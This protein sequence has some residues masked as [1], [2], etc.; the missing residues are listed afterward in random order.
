MDAFNNWRI[1]MMAECQG[2]YVVRLSVYSLLS[3]KKRFHA[4]WRARVKTIVRRLQNR[5]MTET[6]VLS[7]ILLK[8][9]LSICLRNLIR[10]TST[11]A[12]GSI[13]SRYTRPLPPTVLAKI[14]G[15]NKGK[16]FGKDATAG[17]D[18]QRTV[19]FM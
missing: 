16:P 6:M 9:S 13:R 17:S 1:D 14:F 4:M 18:L 11:T 15:S 19:N 7:P 8:S 3:R 10:V 12:I 2:C 5:R